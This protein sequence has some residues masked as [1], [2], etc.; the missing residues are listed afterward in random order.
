MKN[1]SKMLKISTMAGVTGLLLSLTNR[2]SA[3]SLTSAQ[4]WLSTGSSSTPITIQSAAGV[5]MPLGQILFTIAVGVL[6][7]VGVIMGVKYMMASA[8]DKA[9][10][11]EKLIWYIVSI[12]VV[13][14]GI[15]ITAIIMNFF[16][17]AGI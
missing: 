12:V 6:V 4:Q 11:K 16:S 9:N 13:T 14:G 1:S 17:D 3:F 7:I 5:F 10:I 8:N 15:G 2:V